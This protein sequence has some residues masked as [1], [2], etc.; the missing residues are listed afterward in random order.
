MKPAVKRRVRLLRAAEVFVLVAG[1]VAGLVLATRYDRI[2]GEHARILETQRRAL[3][4]LQQPKTVDGRDYDAEAEGIA[5]QLQ[6]YSEALTALHEAVTTLGAECNPRRKYIRV[7]MPPPW[8]NIEIGGEEPR[9]WRKHTDEQ[10]KE[11]P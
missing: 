2:I 7:R 5:T 4:E 11:T 6:I 10:P 1:V 3:R 9:N 8:T